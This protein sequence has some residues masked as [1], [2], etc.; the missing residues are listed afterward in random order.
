MRYKI[1]LLLFLISLASSVIMV[2][3]GNNKFCEIDEIVEKGSCTDVQNS[4]YASTFGIKNYY[5]GI[6][7][8]I[9]LSLLTYSQIRYPRRTK[10]N[11]IHIT[12]Y[13]GTA[14]ALYFI[15]LQQFVLNA[16]CRYCMVID[17]SMVLAFFVVFSERRRMKK[18]HFK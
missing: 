1:L 11:L 5:Y 8:F 2:F 9:L 17:I 15:Y 12:V 6:V 3:D 13:I 7:I 10:R 16:Y 18:W 4:A 14:I